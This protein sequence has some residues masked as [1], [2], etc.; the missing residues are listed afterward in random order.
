[1]ALQ[2]SSDRGPARRRVPGGKGRDDDR[3]APLPGGGWQDAVTAIISRGWM[4]PL[5]PVNA[6][7]AM[8]QARYGDLSLQGLIPGLVADPADGWLPA[9]TLLADRDKAP[10][11]DKAP[12]RETAP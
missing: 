3:P 6:T 10:D 9:T 12:D 8:M 1:M 2:W 5:A 4:S 11:P 7:L